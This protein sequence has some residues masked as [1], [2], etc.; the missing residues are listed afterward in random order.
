MIA[1]SVA[2]TY[3]RIMIKKDYIISSQVDCDPYTEVCFI[4]EC[5][6]VS[7]VEGEKCTGNPEND[8]WY[9]KVAQRNA[10]RIPLCDPDQDENCQ[11]MKCEENE[12]ECEEI[13]CTEDQ[14]EAQYASGCVDPVKYTEE[15]PLEEEIE[16]AESEIETESETGIE[17]EIETETESDLSAD[18]AEN[19]PL[20]ATE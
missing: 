5:D 16:E 19:S 12:E 10:G 15:N 4:W 2:A 8:I 11:P 6:P 1:L 3:W 7:T 9:F 18:E 17:S 14:L 20:E 13:L